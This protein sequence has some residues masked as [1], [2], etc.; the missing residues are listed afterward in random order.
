MVGVLAL[1]L[2]KAGALAE[3]GSP[4][5]LCFEEIFSSIGGVGGVS[6]ST[7]GGGV[8]SIIILTLP[9]LHHSSQGIGMGWGTPSHQ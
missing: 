2:K 6:S 7:E 8:F 9:R 1:S 5:A 4:L 3:E